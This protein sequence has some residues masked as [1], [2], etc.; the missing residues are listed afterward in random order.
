GG[1]APY[2]SVAVDES[3]HRHTLNSGL[4]KGNY[5]VHLVDSKGCVRDYPHVTVREINCREDFH[6]NPFIGE[7]WELPSNGH[8]ADF[9]VFERSS[10]LYYERSF[11]ATEQLQ[12]N[13]QSNKGDIKEGYFV[14]EIIYS[15]GSRKNG[16]ITVVK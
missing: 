11:Q 2:T 3:G 10:G 5:V 7:L 8:T 16:S 13:G 14:F 1:H 4:A 9:R 12:W 6:F 15:D